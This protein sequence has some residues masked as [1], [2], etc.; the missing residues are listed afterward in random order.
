M[1]TIKDVALK[2]GFSVTTVSKALN[3]YP[4]ISASTKKMILNLCDE[5]GYIPNLS[6]RSLVTQKSYTIG[7]IFEES[8]GIG[9][10]HP[11]FSKILEAFKSVVES[12]GY[13]ILF[14]SKN[15]GKSNGSYLQHARRKQAE[16]ILVLCADFEAEEMKKLYKSDIP[17][18][19][20]DYGYEELCNV[21]SNNLQGLD[22]AVK[23][24]KSLG[25]KKIGQIYGGQYLYIGR[26]RKLF[27]E[28]SMKKHELE[29]VEEYM[30]SGE[31]FSKEDGYNGMKTLLK[32]EDP[33]TAI[34]CASDMI[35]IGAMQAIHETGLKVPDDISI[36]GFDGIDIGQLITPRLTT[37]RQDSNKMGRIAANHILQ[38]INEKNPRK[39]TTT[40]TVD[41]YLITGDST[42]V[43][44]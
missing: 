42:K 37:I 8:T 23:Y 3:D 7:I 28:Q 2:S 36:I 26:Q 41:T 25:H 6:A 29:I 13:D 5:M 40:V 39:F 21:T 33:P 9:L 4:D 27:F 24:F 14:L 19:V 12:N 32:L 22:K 11:L 31:F 43:I 38:M 10:Q 30:T 44:R 16:A 20:I 15:M 18:I 35:A 34:F 1:I 17:V